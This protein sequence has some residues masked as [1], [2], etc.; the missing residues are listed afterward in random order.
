M[1][2]STR[3]PP[4]D[5]LTHLSRLGETRTWE[6]GTAVVRQGEMADCLYIV[7]SGEL[8]AVLAGEGARP[9]ELNTLRAGEFFGELMLSGGLR[10]ATVEVT[11]RAQLTRVPRAA[12]EQLLTARPD[13]ALH[14]VHSLVQRVRTLTGTVGRLASVDVYGRLVG[15]FEALVKPGLSSARRTLDQIVGADSSSPTS[16]AL[17]TV[18]AAGRLVSPFGT[19]NDCTGGSARSAAGTGGSIS[20]KAT[21]HAKPTA[22]TP[23]AMRLEAGGWPWFVAATRVPV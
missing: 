17:K 7:H 16:R 14:L 19:A 23:A 15:L 8:R 5:F 18:A 4:D 22:S 13:L 2:T 6:A 1:P 9:V 10:A 3:E 20:A 11:V 21:T 12:V